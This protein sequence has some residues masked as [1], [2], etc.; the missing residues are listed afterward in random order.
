MT[1]GFRGIEVDEHTVRVD[2]ADESLSDDLISG[3]AVWGHKRP[4]GN[5]ERANDG[6]CLGR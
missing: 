1:M 6:N 3:Q 2:E 5:L 4:V